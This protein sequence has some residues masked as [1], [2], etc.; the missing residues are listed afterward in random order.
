MNEAVVLRGM[1]DRAAYHKYSPALLKL[2]T[3]EREHRT[4]LKAVKDYWKKFPDV[5][6]MSPEELVVFFNQQNP[7]LKDKELYDDILFR[8]KQSNI[9]NQALL[10]DELNNLIETQIANEILKHCIAKVEQTESTVI[11]KIKASVDRFYDI[12]GSMVV[13]D[14]VLGDISLKDLLN[15]QHGDINWRLPFLQTALGAPPAGTLGHI[16]A[17]PDTGKTTLAISEAVMMARQ[18]KGTKDCVL[19]LGNEEA[20][21]RTYLRAFCSF[22]GADRNW[23]EAPEN[24]AKADEYYTRFTETIKPNL[25]CVDAVA[26]IYTVEENFKIFKPK[27]SFIDQGP[28]V[29]IPGVDTGP[30]QV[31]RLYNWYR[32]TA[33]KYNIA[34]ITLGQADAK[35]ENKQRLSLQN[36]DNSKVGLPGEL[37]YAIG[38]SR[39]DDAGM[40]WVR[41]L[42]ITKNK[43]TGDLAHYRG[44]MDR[45]KARYT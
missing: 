9:S 38:I 31:K 16:Y 45:L 20:I 44:Y 18:M 19:Y 43:L 14:N 29:H 30:E 39:K 34:L 21:S 23:L 5:E 25:V 2:K 24:A 37:D 35:A 1:L 41:F 17:T 4:I 22:I 32:E 6:T 8:V 36:I 26:D 3:L 7:A 28:K 10:A 15:Q 11:E 13:E 27:V 42:T 12:T 33:K 40:E